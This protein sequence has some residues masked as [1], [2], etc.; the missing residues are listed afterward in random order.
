MAQVLV[1]V[2]I[3]L[4][5]LSAEKTNATVYYSLSH[6]SFLVVLRTTISQENK[7]HFLEIT[8]EWILLSQE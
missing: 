5:D 6:Y 4:R 7:L 2:Q 8:R 1:P 3:Q